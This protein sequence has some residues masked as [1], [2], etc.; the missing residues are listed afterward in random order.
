MASEA[1]EINSRRKIS[2]SEYKELMIRLRVYPD[3][4]TNIA[5]LDRGLITLKNVKNKGALKSWDS[6]SPP[7][8]KRGPNHAP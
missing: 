7:H 1:L 3:L 8:T 5:A 4:P 2:L 6:Q